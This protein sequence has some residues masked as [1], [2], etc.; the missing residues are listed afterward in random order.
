MNHL[1]K[2]FP[3]P[4][5]I[6]L[7]CRCTRLAFFSINPQTRENSL[8]AAVVLYIGSAFNLLIANFNHTWNDLELTGFVY[9]QSHL[10]TATLSLN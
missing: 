3:T 10:Q 5:L 8:I 2:E 1:K 4:T 6:P 7:Y 9:S